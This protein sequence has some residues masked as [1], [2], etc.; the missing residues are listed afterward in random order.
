MVPLHKDGTSQLASRLVHL[1]AALRYS[2]PLLSRGEPRRFAAPCI[3]LSFPEAPGRPRP[4]PLTAGSA[5]P[6]LRGPHSPLPRLLRSLPTAAH[7]RLLPL[8]GASRAA[9]LRLQ[10][11][12]TRA[13]RC[14]SRCFLVFSRSRGHFLNELSALCPLPRGNSGPRPVRSS[15]EEGARCGTCG[16]PKCGSLCP[17]VSG[18]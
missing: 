15:V 6:A 17:V 18:E 14:G 1:L 5:T 10:W 3:P 2:Q 4:T 9:R 11:S 16:T 8:P 7:R 12:C 13:R